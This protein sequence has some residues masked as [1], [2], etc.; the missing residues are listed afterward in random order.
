MQVLICNSVSLPGR[1][2]EQEYPGNGI[3]TT[4]EWFRCFFLSNTC[5]DYIT[6]GERSDPV[7]SVCNLHHQSG[8]NTSEKRLRKG[9]GWHLSF[10]LPYFLSAPFSNL[11]FYFLF[12]SLN[13]N[14]QNIN[15]PT[16][17]TRKKIY[18]SEVCRVN[19]SK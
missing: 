5:L 17:Q 18:G 2:K 16:K 6:S 4:V 7:T 1:R 19:M 9:E 15:L 10:F 14:S 11:F 3:C 12:G 8:Y 13:E